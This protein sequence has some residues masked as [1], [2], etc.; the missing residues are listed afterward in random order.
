MSRKTRYLRVVA[1]TK[2]EASNTARSDRRDDDLRRRSSSVLPREMYASSMLMFCLSG[3]VRGLG[4][5]SLERFGSS[6]ISVQARMTSDMEI[7]SRKRQSASQRVH[8]RANPEQT[9]RNED[10]LRINHL[11]FLWHVRYTP[12]LASQGMCAADLHFTHDCVW[13]PTR[14]ISDNHILTSGA[15]P[16]VCPPLDGTFINCCY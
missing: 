15:I 2:E 11:N 5:C 9:Y 1:Y 12:M 6:R 14:A 10:V 13:S 7:E 8:R 4:S 3:V 16:D